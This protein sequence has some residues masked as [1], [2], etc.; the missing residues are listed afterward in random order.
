MESSLP[1]H[2][3]YLPTNFPA[4][5]SLPL[6]VWGNGACSNDGTAFEGFL[7]NIASYGFLVVAN[8]PPGGS[9]SSN[10]AMLGA[11]ITWVGNN[12]GTNDKYSSVDFNK[13]AA[14]GQSCGGL[15]AYI[16][17]SDDRVSLLGIF[18]SGFVA[19][20]REDPSMINE[21][22]KPTFYF[23]GG[24]TDIAYENVSRYSSLQNPC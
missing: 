7:T 3:F 11:A 6:L 10:D 4:N 12:I 5:V 23:L 14:A 18:N 19:G 1:D 8:G 17:R 9:G 21:V 24:S 22:H 16:L 2:T 15:E 20:Y 13:I